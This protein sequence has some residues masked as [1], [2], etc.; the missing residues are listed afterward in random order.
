MP[1][2]SDLAEFPETTLSLTVTLPKAFMPRDKTSLAKMPPPLSPAELS[3][4]M[5]L[6]TVTLP[7]P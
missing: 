4:I 2:P 1:P 3:E 7:K 5:L 6:L